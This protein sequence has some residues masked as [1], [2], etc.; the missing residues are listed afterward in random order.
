MEFL[1]FGSSIPGSYWGCCA[2]CIIQ[3]FRQDPKAKA[4]I[5]IVDGDHC[6]PQINSEGKEI[7]VGPT[8]EDIFWQRLRFGTFS[9]KNMPNHTFLAILTSE[10]VAG[11]Y[12]KQWLAILKKAGFE[13]IRAFDNSV[14]TG[15]SLLNEEPDLAYCDEEDWDDD[16]GMSPHPNYLFGLFRNIGQGAI[17]N[18]FEPPHQWTEL[19]E[20]V[21]EPYALVTDYSAHNA[22]TQAKQ[23]ELY[24]ALPEPKWYTEEELEAEG[25]TVT[26]AAVRDVYGRT[27]TIP[28][29]TKDK[30]NQRKET[31][32]R[33]EKQTK[34]KAAP[35]A[36]AKASPTTDK[37]MSLLSQ[38]K[39]V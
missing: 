14:Y 23:T 32:D 33:Q 19:S 9:Q 39:A 16:T 4:S 13:F 30:R 5:Q 17:S 1:R 8:W 22:V 15:S 24:K 36:G 25:V 35:F 3:D 34:K 37:T 18:P 26:Y 20:V 31:S 27:P 10:Q 21:P 38:E 7:F 6:S 11:G 29:E 12:G 2:C 28:Q